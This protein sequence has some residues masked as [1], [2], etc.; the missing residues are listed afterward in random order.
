MIIKSLEILIALFLITGF[1]IANTGG[2][3]SDET[4]NCACREEMSAPEGSLYQC[5]NSIN[6]CKLSRKNVNYV[7]E[8]TQPS[9]KY[10]KLSVSA[11]AGKFSNIVYSCKIRI[12]D[13]RR[14]TGEYSVKVPYAY[15]KG[16]TWEDRNLNDALIITYNVKNQQYTFE[17]VGKMQE[18]K[19]LFEGAKVETYLKQKP[20]SPQQMIRAGAVFLIMDYPKAMRKA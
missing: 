1:A 4:S 13:N 6:R 12:Y 9:P 17:A 18:F 19:E 16:Y 7:F 5:H 10:A 20:F 11:A 14:S 2:G 15:Y 8:W 3:E